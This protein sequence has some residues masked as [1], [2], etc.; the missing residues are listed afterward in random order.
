[1]AGIAAPPRRSRA[2][3]PE[4]QTL[5]VDDVPALRLPG[6]RGAQTVQR[7]LERYPG[8]SVWLPATLEYALLSPW[9]N[10][11]E[12]AHVEELVAVGQAETLLRAALER[13]IACGDDLM[14]AIELES[15]RGPSRFARAGLDLLEE[16]I[17]YEIDAPRQPWVPRRGVR[18][19]PVAAGD[20]RAIDVLV[21]IDGAAF[22]WLWRNNRDEFTVYLQTPGVDVALLESD[23][24]PL[25]YVGMTHFAGWSHLDRIA[26]AP[27][28]QGR[29][30]G[31]DALGLAVG[32]MRRQGAR[33]IS[34]ST[35]RTNLRS[36]R[37]YER[38]GFWRTPEMDYRLF[39]AWCRAD[40]A[41]DQ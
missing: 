33:R 7:S 4:A 16:V 25:G 6:L 10:R 18:L 22:P 34:L 41:R 3:V 1:M 27:A 31:R 20:D 26:V 8:R 36:Q 23:G 15:E 19:I 24:E 30:L 39:G 40:R 17:T 13:C 21:A 2:V 32:E 12:I 38:F 9:R 29:G 35:Q 5:A 11:P 28:A 37:L 14:L